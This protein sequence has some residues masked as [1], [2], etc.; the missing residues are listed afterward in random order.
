M[1]ES[2]SDPLGDKAGDEISKKKLDALLAKGEAEAGAVVQSAVEKFAGQ[3]AA[4]ISRFLRQKTWRK[5]ER[6]I[7][8][9]GLRASRVGELAIARACILLKEAGTDIYV[10]GPIHN[11]PDEAGL[12]GT[13]H[14]LTPWMVKGHDAMLAVDVG[15]TNIRAGTVALNA[16][17]ARDLSKASVLDIE[18]LR[19][20]D[21]DQLDRD[22]AVKRLSGMLKKLAKDAARNNL[23][24]APVIGVGCPGLIREDGSIETGAQNLPGNWQSSRFNLPRAL[25][26]EIPRIGEH[27]TMVVM[28]NDAVVQGLS[29]LPHVEARRWAVLTIDTGLGNARFSMRSKKKPKH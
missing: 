20:R 14:L 1:R 26:E 5:T 24:L 2:G 11:Q 4:V 9:G 16:G 27:E 15:G 25:R 3:L 28:H 29:E 10:V 8:G 23:R 7:V 18:A 22:E 19:H 17:K 6:I 12:I 21:E 13:A